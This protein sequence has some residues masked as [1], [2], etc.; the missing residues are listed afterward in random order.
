[1]DQ[2]KCWTGSTIFFSIRR[3][4]STRRHL[5]KASKIFPDGH[6]LAK[7]VSPLSIFWLFEHW[8]DCH[9]WFLAFAGIWLLRL[10]PF[11]G[12][13]YGSFDSVQVLWFWALILCSDS[14]QLLGFWTAPTTSGPVSTVAVNA[15]TMGAALLNTWWSLYLC[16][17]L[18]VII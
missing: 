16:R 4:E 14:V 3:L 15:D 12:Y 2:Y 11:P 13:P 1:M 6:K 17:G 10:L 8:H 9:R 18:L 5:I 7:M